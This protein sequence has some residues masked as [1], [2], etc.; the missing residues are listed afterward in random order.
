MPQST[1]RTLS[2]RISDN[3]E[4]IKSIKRDLEPRYPRPSVKYN[5]SELALHKCTASPDWKSKAVL[6]DSTWRYVEIFLRDKRADEALFYWEQ[7]H[8]FFE[9][10]EKLSLV[11]APLTAYY[12]FLNA[13]KALLTLK[14]VNFGNYHGVTGD[15]VQ[16]HVHLQNEIVELKA[17]GILAGMCSYL[18]EPP[19]TNGENHTLKDILYN[20]QYIHRAFTLTYRN[21]AELFIP[22][23]NARFVWDKSQKKAWLQIDLEERYS[24]KATLNK[25]DGFSADNHFHKDDLVTIRTDDTFDWDAPR[26]DPTEQSLSNL[27]LYYRNIRTRLRYIYPGFWYIKRQDT[28]TGIINRGTLPLTFVAMHR[29]S[30]MARYDPQSLKKHLET[31]ASWLLSEFITKAPYQFMDQIS[32]EITGVDFKPTGFR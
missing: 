22:F 31:K 18:G 27:G 10:S 7:A 11:S 1:H 8:D 16:G 14:N 29:L 20:L 21:V 30:E 6:A 3:A 5:N 2:R 12:C 15:G 26:N 13:T 17:G 9:A 32:S 4:Q 24:S 28:T 23:Q 25:L 19:T